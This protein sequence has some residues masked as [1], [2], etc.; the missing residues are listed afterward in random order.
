MNTTF[1][2]KDKTLNPVQ[3]KQFQTYPQLVHYLG[4]MCKRVYGQTKLERTQL[5]ESLGHGTDDYNSTLF[6]R[7][8]QDQYDIGVIR[9]NRHVRCDVTVL[10]AYQKPEYGD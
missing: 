2:V 8:M 9:E 5:L 6:V 7:S 4:E 1:Y 10:V 3:E